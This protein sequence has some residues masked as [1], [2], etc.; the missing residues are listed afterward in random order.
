MKILISG[1]AGFIGS[2]IA[3]LAVEQGHEIVGIDDLSTGNLRNLRSIEKHIEFYE[4]DI[5]VLSNVLFHAFKNVDYV[6]HQ[7]AK[8]AVLDSNELMADYH[9]TNVTGTFN[10]L[11]L[12]K[13][14]KVK[15]VVLAS[16]CAMQ[17]DSFYGMTKLINEQYAKWFN[18]NGLETV[19]LRYQNVYGPRQ[20]SC[21]MPKFIRTLIK[22]ESPIIYGDGFQTR[23]FIYVKDIAKANL[24][25]LKQPSIGGRYFDIA[26]GE[27]TTI[28]QIYDRIQGIL[29]VYIPPLYMPRPEGE[30]VNVIPR[31]Y[32]LQ[33]GWKPETA[34]ETGLI[35]T[36]NYYKHLY[37][38]GKI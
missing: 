21:V 5:S 14:H 28:W 6:I 23:D 37:S 36:V 32:Q 30:I 29:G 8:I 4:C 35:E 13:F 9:C 38:D 20:D 22:G 11:N 33:L 16:S 34:L 19:C 12:S 25:A 31:I 27:V 26:S 17:G 15:R 18:K 24:I 1:I 10:I 2:H 3:E 7:A